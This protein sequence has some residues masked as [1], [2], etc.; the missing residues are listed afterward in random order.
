MDNASYIYTI[1]HGGRKIEEF[2]GLLQL[3]HIRY[4]V[5][6]RS[7][8]RSRFYPHFNKDN[9]HRQLL[10][11]GIGYLFLGDSLGGL[12]SDPECYDDQ[13]HVVYD[14]LRG[15]AYFQEGLNRLVSA[16]EK[17]INIACMCSEINACECHRSKLIGTSL[18]ELKIQMLHI[19]RAGSIETQE[20]VMRDVLNSDGD[21]D[22]FTTTSSSLKSRKPYR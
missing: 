6:V 11:Q 4:V 8:P 5:D 2:V 7:K 3:H 20:S 17:R 22:L 9:L 13:G 1:G 10:S 19:N 16:N 15:K 18:S 21:Q 12:P 14:A